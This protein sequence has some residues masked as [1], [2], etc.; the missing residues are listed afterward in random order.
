MENLSSLIE[1]IGEVWRLVGK[2]AWEVVYQTKGVWRDPTLDVSQILSA[3]KWG[4]FYT[5]LIL[6]GVNNIK[7]NGSELVYG[8]FIMEFI[9]NGKEWRHIVFL[10]FF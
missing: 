6:W 5:N 2:L 10:V 9:Y 3:Q 4:T 7:K 1:R 8:I